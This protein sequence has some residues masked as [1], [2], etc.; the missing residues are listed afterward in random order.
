MGICMFRLVFSNILLL[1]IACLDQLFWNTFH[2]Y[3][4]NLLLCLLE[5]VIECRVWNVVANAKRVDGNSFEFGLVEESQSFKIFFAKHTL[6]NFKFSTKAWEKAMLV[7]TPILEAYGYRSNGCIQLD[8]KHFDYLHLN[9]Q[10]LIL[11]II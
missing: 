5:P 8:F 10:N 3:K 7:N 9:Y 11:N 1:F 2:F 6:S 4:Y